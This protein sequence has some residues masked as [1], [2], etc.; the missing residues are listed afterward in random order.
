M[1]D[2]GYYVFALLI[3]VVGLVIVKKVT[4]CLIKATVAIVMIAILAIAYWLYF[5]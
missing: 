5:A 1:S 4:T 2:F 3:L